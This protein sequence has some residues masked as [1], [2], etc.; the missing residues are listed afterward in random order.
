MLDAAGVYMESDYELGVGRPGGDLDAKL[1][2]PTVRPICKKTP[3]T[4]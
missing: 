3:K 1:G 2:K 4:P